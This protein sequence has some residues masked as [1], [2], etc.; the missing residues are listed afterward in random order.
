[1]VHPSVRAESSGSG[2][3]RDGLGDLVDGIA[4]DV[5]LSGVI[6]VD[7]DGSLAV[8][9][10]YGLAHRGLGVPT[11]VDTQFAIASGSKGLTALTV[12]SLVERGELALDTT[13]RSVLGADLPLIDD[14]VTV[15][16]LLAHRSGIGD[17][18][19]ED[20]VADNNDYVLTVPVHEL[21]TTEQFLAV[22]DG[23]PMKYEP[24]ERFNYCNGGY[25][26][27]ALLAERASGVPFHDL[28]DQRVCRPAGMTDTSFLRS[29]ELPGRAAVGYLDDEGLRTNVL[30]L[31]VRG[32][33]DGGIYTTAAD[34]HALWDAL[35]AGRI[36]SPDTVAEMV[37]PR[38]ERAGGC[39]CA[40]GSASGST[41][42]PARC[43]ST[44]STPASGSSP[45]TIAVTGSPPPCCATRPVGHGRSV[46]AS[47]NCSHHRPD[48]RALRWS[49]VDEE[50][51]EVE[52][53]RVAVG[54][55]DLDAVVHLPG[56]GRSPAASPGVS[57]ERRQRHGA[58]QLRGHRHVGED[59]AVAG[60]GRA[61]PGT[62]DRRW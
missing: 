22:L 9:R 10:A 25:V 31:P 3:D 60:A 27:L 42:R 51:G 23:H 24:G 17:Y 59:A 28:V 2:D 7:L 21:A 19:D 45:S 4:A 40:T 32:N 1:M 16:Q 15:E 12:M 11:T 36:V 29:D 50:V 20:E 41:T 58:G 47:T 33:G 55:H 5:G 13:A 6:R 54:V 52:P 53:L 26:V 35:F 62:A 18:L 14:R 34:V 38:S 57:E 49:V 46:N 8:Q 39:R 61:T 56:R 48:D 43:R 44:A 37:R 30:H